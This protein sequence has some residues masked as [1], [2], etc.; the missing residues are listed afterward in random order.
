LHELLFPQPSLLWPLPPGPKDDSIPILKPMPSVCPK[1]LLNE[2]SR[3]LTL[4][5]TEAIV[6]LPVNMNTLLI[7]LGRAPLGTSIL[8]AIDPLSA[9]LV[10]GAGECEGEDT[11]TAS[12]RARHR[13]AGG[14]RGGGG[15]DGVG[16]HLLTQKNKCCP[17]LSK[18][19]KSVEIMMNI[20]QIII[21]C[22]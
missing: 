14:G 17:K 3:Q 19:K 9:G 10:S 8:S 21:V 15:A 6:A 20:I 5:P 7:H 11:L 13:G 1:Y 22:G 4:S 18:P 2:V 16:A 12:V